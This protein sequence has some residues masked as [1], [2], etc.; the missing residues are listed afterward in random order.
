MFKGCPLSPYLFILVA[1]IL[2]HNIRNNNSIKGI[3]LD[4]YEHKISQFADDTENLLLFEESTLRELMSTMDK[5]E[6]FSGLG[7]NTDK[8]EIMRIGAAKH[9]TNELG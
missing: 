7:V 3:T 8:T 1:E 2:S 5:F 6:Q 4:N 9:F